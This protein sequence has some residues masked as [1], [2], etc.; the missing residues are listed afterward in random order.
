MTDVT[1]KQVVRNRS[2]SDERTLIPAS[3]ARMNCH[4]QT[5]SRHEEAGHDCVGGNGGSVWFYPGFRTGRGD[6]R[7]SF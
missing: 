4:R 6:C 2:N 1:F 5:C 3:T 7:S